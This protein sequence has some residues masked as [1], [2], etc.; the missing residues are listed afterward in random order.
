[1]CSLVNCNRFLYVLSHV[2]EDK[3][4]R[5]LICTKETRKALSP[6]SSR[7]KSESS[8]A[9]SQILQNLPLRSIRNESIAP[10]VNNR[11]I[12][13]DECFLQISVLLHSV[14]YAHDNGGCV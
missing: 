11:I 3:A 4:V 12:G 7:S 13:F 5:D 14:R 2:L 6:T 10:K 1:M 8:V 9:S